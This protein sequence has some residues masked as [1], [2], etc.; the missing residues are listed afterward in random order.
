MQGGT[1]SSEIFWDIPLTVNQF[2]S[3]ILSK[4]M[5]FMKLAVSVPLRISPPIADKIH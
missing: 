4:S 5:A 1:S 3:G 2:I